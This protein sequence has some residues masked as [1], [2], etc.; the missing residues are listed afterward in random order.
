MPVR[1]RANKFLRNP[2]SEEE[3][4]FRGLITAPIYMALTGSAY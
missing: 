1:Y 4:V 2:Y 3:I